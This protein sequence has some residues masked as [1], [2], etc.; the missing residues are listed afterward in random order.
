MRFVPL[1]IGCVA[2]AFGQSGTVPKPQAA[3]YEVHLQAKHASVGAEFMIHSFSGE[4][5]TYIA[6]DYLVVEVALY[7]PKDHTVLVKAPEF[8]LR[9]NGKRPIQPAPATLLAADFQHP[10][11]STRPRLEG[12][13]G[14]GPVGVIL[15]R[16]RPSRVPGEQDPGTPRLPRVPDPDPPGGLAPQPRL[17]AEE[18]VVK[19]ALPEGTFAGPV[20][21]FL[22]FPY[23]GK[24]ASIKSAEL[25]YD[26]A[27]VKLR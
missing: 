9:V 14:S 7:P 17:T 18:L 16:P 23:K 26:E 3:D 12:S 13:A 4:G 8:S 5:A 2:L 25:L 22:Y 11:W 10:D 1:C 15:G 27:V 6:P 19:V 24:V 21:G 20:S